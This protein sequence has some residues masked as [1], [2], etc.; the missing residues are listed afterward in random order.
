VGRIERERLPGAASGILL[1]YAVNEVEAAE[2]E[3]LLGRLLEAA[4]RGARLLV[5]EP[6]ARRLTPWWDAW[7]EAFRRGGGRDDTW[8]FPA[9]LPERLRL[10]DRAAGLDHRELTARSLS[11]GFDPS[12]ASRVG[13]R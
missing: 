2:R 10:L 4:G 7:A 1:A 5:V 6:I 8:R 9:E 13:T 3:R 11:V 12:R